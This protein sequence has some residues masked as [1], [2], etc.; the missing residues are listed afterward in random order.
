MHHRRVIAGILVAG[1]LV[2]GVTA[3][4]A[5]AA[6]T[7]CRSSDRAY[8]AMARDVLGK[9]ADYRACIRRSD[10]RDDCSGEFLFLRGAQER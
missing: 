5:L 6:D 2:A 10:G 3:A 8:R 1:I 7:A 4:P 9:L